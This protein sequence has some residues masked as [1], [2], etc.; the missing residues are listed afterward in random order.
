[1]KKRVYILVTSDGKL[2]PE[3][4]WCTEIDL[5]KPILF[6]ELDTPMGKRFGFTQ[7][8]KKWWE[9]WK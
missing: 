6:Q 3:L 8:I 9:F 7:N 2:K 1:M 5:G 4:L